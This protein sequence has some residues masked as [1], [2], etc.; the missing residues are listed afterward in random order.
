M[1]IKETEVR[2]V[3][4]ASVRRIDHTISAGADRCPD[5]LRRDGFGIQPKIIGRNVANPVVV[6]VTRD[7]D[8]VHEITL[9]EKI[10]DLLTIYRVPIPLFISECN[11][12]RT[13]VAVAWRK[14][15]LIREQVP[16]GNRSP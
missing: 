15:N 12:V 11:N 3:D 13:R 5:E 4:V 14:R 9:D 7:D 1:I 10:Q 2:I 6:I 8:G 16:A